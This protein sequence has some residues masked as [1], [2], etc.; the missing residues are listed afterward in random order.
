MGL[1]DGLRYVYCIYIYI[2][3][4]S[5]YNYI[6]INSGTLKYFYGITLI[7]FEWD[8]MSNMEFWER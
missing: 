4:I 1:I 8:K 3:H 6:I 2:Y 5:S 7:D